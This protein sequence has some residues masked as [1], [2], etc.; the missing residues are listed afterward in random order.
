METEGA[1]FSPFQ[2]IFGNITKYII[3]NMLLALSRPSANR[4]VFKSS[5]N[6]LKMEHQLCFWGNVI[7]GSLGHIVLMIYSRTRDEYIENTS[8]ITT[9]TGWVSDCSLVSVQHFFY[10]IHPIILIFGIYQSDPF[11]LPIYKNVLLFVVLLINIVFIV[12]HFSLYR[13]L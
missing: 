12:A 10:S 5:A 4:T 11:K 13:Y 3:L 2:L 8:H 7:L 6:F 9:D 1:F